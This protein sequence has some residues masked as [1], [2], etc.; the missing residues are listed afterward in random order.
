MLARDVR[1]IL[2]ASSVT[3]VVQLTCCLAFAQTQAING[4]MRGRLTDPT[5]AAVPTAT[6]SVTNDA[7]GYARDVQSNDEGYF[8]IPNLPLGTYTMTIKKDGF[9]TQRRPGIVL[10]AGVEAVIDAQWW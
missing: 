2:I 9:E 4:S 3:V 7:T 1:H 8:V 6:V 5:D 10:G